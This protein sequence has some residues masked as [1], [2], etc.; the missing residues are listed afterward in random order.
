MRDMSNAFSWAPRADAGMDRRRFL[1]RSGSLLGL[2]L[3]MGLASMKNLH[4]D[5]HQ[6]F[7]AHQARRRKELWACWATCPSRERPR[8]SS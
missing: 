3:G 5:D 4:A 7:L 6:E 1:G 8:P 2:G